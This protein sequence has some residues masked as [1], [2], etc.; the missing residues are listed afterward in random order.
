MVRLMM[1]LQGKK[2]LGLQ[3]LKQRQAKCCGRQGPHTLEGALQI[4][5]SLRMPVTR[6]RTTCRSLAEAEKQ[7]SKQ[8]WGLQLA[9]GVTDIAARVT[10]IAARVTDI[11]AQVT[12]IVMCVTD[13]T[14]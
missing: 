14:M 7:M 8:T 3:V 9:Y 6:Y 10:D 1:G 2:F 13:I 5:F 4:A 12:N 11:A